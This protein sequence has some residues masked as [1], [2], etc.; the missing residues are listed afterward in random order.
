[1]A[2]G[3]Y[4]DDL[5]QCGQ[6]NLQQ[7]NTT[8]LP[9]EVRMN[10]PSSGIQSLQSLADYRGGT[11]MVQVSPCERVDVG[12]NHNNKVGSRVARSHKH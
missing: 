3:S 2:H 8:V 12:T 1:M 9:N 4:Q 6:L 5:L 11:P 10:G 7:P